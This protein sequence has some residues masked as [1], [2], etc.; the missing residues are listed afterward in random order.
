MDVVKAVEELKR[1]VGALVER[2]IAEF[3][4]LGRKGNEEWF[5]ELCFCILTANSSAELG[6]KI[7]REVGRGFLTLSEED[8]RNKLKLL[9]H[10]FYNTRAK[11]IVEA[12]KFEK[13]KDVLTAME[14]FDARDWLVKNVR[15]VGY[16]EASHFLRNVG[17]LDFAILDRHILRIL[18]DYKLIEMPRSL[19]RKRYLEIEEIFRELAKKVELKPGELDLYLWYMRTGRV[20]K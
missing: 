20:L 4:D 5:S 13:I 6:M 17:Y 12:R 14:P 16:K 8:L 15:G 18:S 7:Q 1:K 9:G 19:S 2:R 10:R 3:I 11:Y